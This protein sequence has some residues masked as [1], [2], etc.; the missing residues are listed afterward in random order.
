[1]NNSGLISSITLT[2]GGAGYTSVPTVTI[3]TTDNGVNGTATAVLAANATYRRPAQE[4]SFD[5]SEQAKNPNSIHYQSKFNPVWVRKGRSISVIPEGGIVMHIDIPTTSYD[6]ETIGSVPKPFENAVVIGS[7]IKHTERYL[8][9][10]TQNEIPLYL[11]TSIPNVPTFSESMPAS[12]TAPTF[13]WNPT[14]LQSRF[15][16]QSIDT[17]Y[18]RSNFPSYV[19]P[20]LEIPT[21]DPI[22]DLVLP[23][24]PAAPGFITKTLNMSEIPTITIVGPKGGAMVINKT[25]FDPK[26]HKLMSD[27]QSSKPASEEKAKTTSKKKT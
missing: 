19:A 16:G 22:A 9:H 20:E 23:D 13:A 15:D 27:V 12:L 18:I 14:V 25:D 2:N 21:L 5:L 7:A 17:T 3:T 4:V 10:F 24:P 6:S 26:S 1:M 8:Q 11:E